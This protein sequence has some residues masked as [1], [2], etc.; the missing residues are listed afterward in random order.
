MSAERS[1]YTSDIPNGGT[2]TPT[3]LQHVIRDDTRYE[4]IGFGSMFHT[5]LIPSDHVALRIPPGTFLPKLEH[6]HPSDGIEGWLL[7]H[8]ELHERL[9]RINSILRRIEHRVRYQVVD[10]LKFI[11]YFVRSSGELQRL[12]CGLSSDRRILTQYIFFLAADILACESGVQRD[13]RL[14]LYM[15]YLSASTS[16]RT[17]DFTPVGPDPLVPETDS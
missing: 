10:V 5:F 1:P 15:A 12:S 16:E 7:I 2:H 6:L 14:R 13:R 11:L 8:M 17:F 3:L 4:C 9:C